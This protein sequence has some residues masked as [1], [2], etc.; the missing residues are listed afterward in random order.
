MGG[1]HN[2]DIVI[3]IS[4]HMDNATLKLKPLLN[5]QMAQPEVLANYVPGIEDQLVTPDP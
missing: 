3:Y 5:V 2:I 4:S 1:T